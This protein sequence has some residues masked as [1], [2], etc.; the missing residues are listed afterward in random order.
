MSYQGRSPPTSRGRMPA[1][2][3]LPTLLLMSP[4]VLALRTVRSVRRIV[5]AKLAVRGLAYPW[6]IPVVSAVGEIIAVLVSL[7]QRDALLPPQAIATTLLLVLAGQAIPFTYPTRLGCWFDAPLVLGATAWLLAN[8]VHVAGPADTAPVLLMILAAVVTGRDGVVPGL[9]VY[10]LSLVV[11]VVAGGTGDLSSTGLYALEV[12]LGLAVGFM[13]R[14]QMHQLTAEREARAGERTRATLAERERIA[15]E[16]HDLV[17]H[18]LSVTLLHLAGARHA[19][20]DG[21]VP[22]ALDALDDAERIGRA[23]MADIRRTV[24]S[25]TAD[26]TPTRPLPGVADI[27]GLVAD[28]RAAGLDVRYDAAGDS[29]ALPSGAGLGL[30]RIVQEALSNVAKHAPG[31]TASVRL[32]LRPREG[33]LSVRNSLDGSRHRTGPGGSGVP[34]MT[35]RATGLGATIMVG[36][37]G[38]G[39]LVD[40]RLPLAGE[41]GCTLRR[42]AT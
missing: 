20:R 39:W 9:V 38:D 10:V 1:T 23:A 15:R 7:A 32:D 13:L 3:I 30:Y 29:T 16:I 33:R 19:L 6:W 25:M 41:S 11:L 37:D 34:G 36:P 8:P 4:G 5:D 27:A 17:A 21:D 18:S 24:S 40:V 31:A 14:W 28:F 2:A 35:A 42:I 12:D 22:D 26:P